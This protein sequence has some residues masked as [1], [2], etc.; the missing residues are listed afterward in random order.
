M[1]DKNFNLLY[2]VVVKNNL[3]KTHKLESA[4]QIGIVLYMHF[5]RNVIF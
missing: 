4:L 5:K 3:K 1:R 2:M